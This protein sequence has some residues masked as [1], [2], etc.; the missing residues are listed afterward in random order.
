MSANTPTS[1]KPEYC[2]LV[3]EC[4][5]EGASFALFRAKVGIAKSTFYHWRKMNPE[6][7]EACQVAD[8]LATV[9]W[10]AVAKRAATNAKAGGAPAIILAGLYNRGAGDWSNK[11]EVV[12]TTKDDD[13]IDLSQLTDE[14]LEA[15]ERVVAAKERIRGGTQ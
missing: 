4:G 11:Q 15:Y 3:K 14:E 7:E 13:Q 8:A 12:T 6:F 2:D 1:Y 10:E 5:A 9:W